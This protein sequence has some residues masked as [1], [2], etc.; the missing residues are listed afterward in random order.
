VTVF[1]KGQVPPVWT[2]KPKT[3][4]TWGSVDTLHFACPSCP[5]RITSDMQS[6]GTSV[7]NRVLRVDRRLRCLKAALT[8]MMTG[9]AGCPTCRGKATET[10]ARP[11]IAIL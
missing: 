10:L 6:L 11:E 7:K 2:W 9:V 4:T 1:P 3:G 8:N 5:H